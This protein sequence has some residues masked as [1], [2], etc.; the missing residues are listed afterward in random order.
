[1]GFFATRARVPLAA[2]CPWADSCPTAFLTQHCRGQ[3]LVGHCSGTKNTVS[4]GGEVVKNGAGEQKKRRKPARSS[5]FLV[6]TP[7]MAPC[8]YLPAMGSSVCRSLLVTPM[9]GG[10]GGLRAAG[11]PRGGGEGQLGWSRWRQWARGTGRGPQRVT[12]EGAA[13]SVAG[14]PLHTPL[15][16]PLPGSYL[17]RQRPRT[18]GTTG[19][20]FLLRLSYHLWVQSTEELER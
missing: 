1:M 4:S 2:S 16:H 17:W 18:L 19:P 9:H 20:R 15:S 7:R 10:N 3:R 8:L 12:V 11:A 5:L 6:Q 13:Q 14:L